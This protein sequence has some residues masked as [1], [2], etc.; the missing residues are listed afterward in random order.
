M[1]NIKSYLLDK[2]IFPK[3]LIIDKPG[4]IYSET[5]K[6]YSNKISSKRRLCLDFEDMVANLQLETEKI[7]GKEE[8]SEIFYRLGK[9]EGASNILIAGN[10][11]PPLFLIEFILHILFKDMGG[12]L[13]LSLKEIDLNKKR[14]ILEYNNILVSRKVRDHSLLIGCF[15][16]IL[17]F[18]LGENIEGIAK[19]KEYSKK[20]FYI[21][22][23]K[24]ENRY[25]QDINLL[26][27]ARD[28]EKLNFP[29]TEE[30]KNK[31]C[32]KDFVKFQ[33]LNISPKGRIY[34]LGN[35]L[36][37]STSKFFNNLA[38]YFEK[39]NKKEIFRKI[40]L[41]NTT[42]ISE[43]ILGNQE[44]EK[45]KIKLIENMLCVFGWGIPEIKKMKNEIFVT[46]NYPQINRYKPIYEALVING[47]LNY[48]YKKDFRAYQIEKKIERQKIIIKYK[49]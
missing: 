8:T 25:I 33:K 2:I 45:D 34:F 23:K 32:F 31:P 46:I 19:P 29:K 49:I 17:S 6:R 9:D 21:F 37:W 47:Y 22:D 14:I 26:K 39:R 15:S 35:P 7:F 40:V 12:W 48:V 13:G 16:G 24:L 5:F 18:L 28:Y 10:K 11:K 42:K 1:V 43:K 27:P 3:R 4:I 38:N 36:F 30:T 44:M 20:G 41:K